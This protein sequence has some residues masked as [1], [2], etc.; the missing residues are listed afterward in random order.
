MYIS[1]HSDDDGCLIV[2]I[3]VAIIT[4]NAYVQDDGVRRRRNENFIT[5]S[6]LDECLRSLNAA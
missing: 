6:S 5:S 4:V 2:N 1:A 3:C